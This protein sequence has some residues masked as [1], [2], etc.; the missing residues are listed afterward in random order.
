[1]KKCRRSIQDVIENLKTMHQEHKKAF[2]GSE[3]ST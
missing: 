3:R 2:I 1:M